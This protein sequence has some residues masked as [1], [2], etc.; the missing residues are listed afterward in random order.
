MAWAPPEPVRLT[1]YPAQCALVLPLREPR[2]EDDELR[3]FDEP[4]IGEPLAMINTAPGEHNWVTHKD[5]A[6]NISTLIVTND[7]GSRL[8]PETGTELSQY[9]REWYSFREDDFTSARGETHTRWGVRRAQEWDIEVETRTILTCTE[10]EFHVHA[11]LDA[12]EG[13]HRIYSKNWKQSLP[14]DNL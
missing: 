9:T 6:E 3:P 5:M 13:D 7:Q 8:M 10:T 11:R 2:P 1:V 14:R 4:V 12:Y